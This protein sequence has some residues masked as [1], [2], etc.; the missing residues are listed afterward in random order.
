MYGKYG[1]FHK[2]CMCPNQHVIAN[3]YELQGVLD[4]TDI[5]HVQV[6]D[7]YLPG[8]LPDGSLSTA[9]LD[10]TSVKGDWGCHADYVIYS[11]SGTWVSTD[12]FF[13]ENMQ[14]T[15]TINP[16]DSW[17]HSNTKALVENLLI[18]G[19]FRHNYTI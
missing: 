17:E 16:Q 12:F 3:D 4:H 9:S 6:I 15:S 5:A 13:V 19:G 2:S 7:M 10:F 11:G 14:T 8:A 18:Q 1:I